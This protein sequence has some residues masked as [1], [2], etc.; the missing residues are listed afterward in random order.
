MLVVHVSLRGFLM[1]L[2][3]GCFV[4]AVLSIAIHD[5]YF[6]SPYAEQVDEQQAE[7]I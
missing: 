7:E 5:Y 6:G 3:G 4:L 1:W 2:F